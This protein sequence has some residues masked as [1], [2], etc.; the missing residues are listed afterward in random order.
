MTRNTRYI[1]RISLLTLVALSLFFHVSRSD[2]SDS[3]QSHAETEP[4][5]Y[6]SPEDR[7]LTFADSLNFVAD[8]S[9]ADS[10]YQ[11]AAA[12]FASVADTGRSLVAL[13]GRASSL[14]RRGYYEKA[15]R[16]IQPD[17]L[18]LR[19]SASRYPIQFASVL[20]ENGRLLV[21][22]DRF[23]EARS[24][25]EEAMLLLESAD[26]F[27]PLVEGYTLQAMGLLHHFQGYYDN[28]LDLYE[29][30]L[31]ILSQGDSAD[32]VHS[33]VPLNNIANIYYRKGM[34]EK[35][36]E[37][38]E[39]V[40]D[41]RE[42]WLDEFHPLVAMSFGNL[43]NVFAAAGEYE[44]SLSHHRQ[45]ATI[46]TA[47]F[48][49][50][51][52][53][54]AASY[55]NMG[56]AL[57]ALGRYDEARRFL[58]RALSI[59]QSVLGI[60][61]IRLAIT[62]GN[63]GEVDFLE[64]N[65]GLAEEII[66][67]AIQIWEFNRL[68]N[69]SG[70]WSALRNLAL[71]YAK[72]SRLPAAV[73]TLN[74]ALILSR[75]NPHPYSVT[76][77]ND[78]ADI[79]S[80][81]ATL[82]STIGSVNK[83]IAV[84]TSMSTN[85]AATTNPSIFGAMDN[86][87]L[88]R[89]FNLKVDTQLKIGNIE[90]T[91]NYDA[92]TLATIERATQLTDLLQREHLP[93][94]PNGSIRTTASNFHGQAVI[95]AS[96]LYEQTNDKRFLNRAFYHAEKRKSRQ[97]S[98]SLADANARRSAEIDSSTAAVDHN[99]KLEIS[100]HRRLIAEKFASSATDSSTISTLQNELFILERTYARFVEALALRYNKYAVLRH[101]V[102]TISPADIQSYMVDDSTT[103]VE[104]VVFDSTLV[105]FVIDQ[106]ETHVVST[107]ITK[108]FDIAVDSLRLAL[109]ERLDRA[110]L[111]YSHATYELLVE[112]IRSFLNTERVVFIPEGKLNFVPFD[113]LLSVEPY[114]PT[115]P[116]EPV[117]FSDHTYLM[118]EK[119]VSYSYSAT[120]LKQTESRQ[121]GPT[122]NNMLA[123]APVFPSGSTLDSTALSFLSYVG[124]DTD[125]SGFSLDSLPGSKEEVE[126]IGGIF[127][128]QESPIKRWFNSNTTILTGRRATESV[129]K[130][131]DLGSY[132]YLHL[133]THGFASQVDP[134][135]SGMLLGPANGVN[136]EDGILRTEEVFGLQ[137]NAELV[138]LSACDTGV[139]FID[140]NEGVMSISRGFILAGANKLIVSLWPSNDTAT[141][142]LMI[143]FYDNLS[144]GMD[145]ASALRGAKV[146]L[147]KEGG[148]L[149]RPHLWS[150]FV[151]LGT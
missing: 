124:L 18:A 57:T 114:I 78:L 17:I 37:I 27:A 147:V 22:L 93:E 151:L 46:W 9:A 21:R 89:S 49:S 126:Y 26:S 99:F 133:A 65:F 52:P 29:Q 130:S 45:A 110:F 36:A 107:P 146:S 14:V 134:S 56:R 39:Q 94:S 88:L 66:G 142:V 96:R 129:L 3:S 20:S 1:V 2:T 34:Y 10:A 117:R 43:G 68:S 53:E 131:S 54:L 41:I 50:E 47:V 44:L 16:L 7:V 61:S 74:K 71:V 136:D 149:A 97:L 76:L 128:L 63:L 77:L 125:R 80:E 83:A 69:H 112:P 141:K 106:S 5:I 28:A 60:N 127:R 12:F 48:G 6:R 79:Q 33:T 13:S 51:H 62:L 115:R 120:L 70:Y 98:F 90:K 84:N 32:V 35:A 4:D 55:N 105:T 148:M 95:L 113:M 132:Q 40:L 86:M 58:N 102:V 75:V 140:D 81:T 15:E 138:V 73:K 122:S 87:E 8:Y 143:R 150:G 108:K 31:L 85:L 145:P 67:A 38:H 109:Q 103:I 64:N 72:T 91:I 144:S 100:R 118:E 137:L 82:E 42:L 116:H 19:H 104:Y 23:E 92:Q 123:M 25:L 111:R 59:K 30:S 135:L 121:S 11:V 24:S 119:I 139:G 101:G